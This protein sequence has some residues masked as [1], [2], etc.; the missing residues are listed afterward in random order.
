MSRTIRVER[1]V[2][3]IKPGKKTATAIQKPG[4]NYEDMTKAELQD[5]AK[6]NGFEGYSALNKSD[7][8]KLL[9][10]Q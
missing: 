2:Q 5:Y 10:G 9:K 8:I 4:T 1:T 6:N 3:D 7:L